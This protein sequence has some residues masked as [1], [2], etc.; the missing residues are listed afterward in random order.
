MKSPDTDGN[1]INWVTQPQLPTTI[2]PNTVEI[3]VKGNREE[4]EAES[5]EEPVNV[6]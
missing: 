6:R 3:M 2:A 4:E 5:E 1:G